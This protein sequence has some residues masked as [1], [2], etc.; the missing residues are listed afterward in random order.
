MVQSEITG[1]SPE[2]AVPQ[3][4]YQ[5][6]FD[7]GLTLL[8]E[9]ME[10]VRSAA[11]NFLIPAGCAYD[12]PKQLGIAAVLADLST[13]GAGKY[14]SRALTLALDNLGVDRSESVGTI[15]AR[16]WGAT[17]ASSLPAALELYADI[18]R[19]PH[20]PDGEVDAVKALALQDLRGLEDEPRSKVLVELRKHHYPPP[21]SNDHR[22]TAAGVEGL[23]GNALRGH[24]ARFFRPAG[25]ILSVA[26][27]I[28]WPALRDC[29]GRLFGDWQGAHDV[30]LT[31]GP[32]PAKQGHLT[33]EVEQTQITVAYGSVPV[34]DPDYYAAMGA[35]NVLSGGMS[36]RLF[37]E[38][39]EKHGL[40]YSVWAS[41]QTMKDRASVVCYAGT[42]NARAQQTLDMLLAELRRLPNGIKREEVERLRAGLKS[43]LIMQQE[44]TASRALALASDWYH[45]GRVR[46][47]DEIQSAIDALTPEA[48][49][50]HLRRHP[51]E[52]FTLVTLG[53]KALST[54]PAAKAPRPRR[55]AAP[56]PRAKAPRK[57]PAKPKRKTPVKAT[58]RTSA[59]TTRKGRVKPAAAARTTAATRRKTTA[60]KDKRRKTTGA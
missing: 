24:H 7:N 47:F 25:T 35:V 14:D 17:V 51:P 44:S 9:R 30:Q 4:V 58:R 45:L 38:I 43:S 46:S 32:A 13:R 23:T 39:R 6:T 2:V 52:D 1:R 10:H 26:G 60:A 36:S 42:T 33:K 31:L 22:G 40:C 54:E 18:L 49:V 48:I 55:K 50:A 59:K 28:D 15:H 19:R 11:L 3:D 20:L 16:Y 21:L 57:A 56:K 12:P 5:H 37:T 27:N 53:P 41:Y 8:A 29:V 34:S